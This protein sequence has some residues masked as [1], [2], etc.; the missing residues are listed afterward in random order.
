M[1]IASDII[2]MAYR[3]TNLIPLGQ[4]PTTNQT[5]EALELLN[6]I[7]MSTIGN[8][9]GDSLNDINIG[10]TYTEETF[11]NQWVPDNTRLLLNI[12][13][14][15]TYLLDPYPRDGQRFAIVDVAGNLSLNNVTVSANGRTIDGLTE[16][17]LIDDSFNG[18]WIYRADLGDWTNIASLEEV[19]TLPF[20]SDFDF[21]F[22]TMLALRLS[23]RFAQSL[24]PESLKALARARSQLHSR[25]EQ[26][27]EVLPDLDTRNFL[28]DKT[29]GGNYSNRDDFNTG[30]PY[31]YR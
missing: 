25:Y 3:E 19:D 6:S 14:P 2:R 8:E 22:T 15:A 10:G 28:S 30:R 12:T 1:T 29:Y 20:P 9:A 17:L 13:A 26:K 27:T 21:Y 16:T 31:P 4:N 7:I 24:T 23:P 5:N 18:Q 11:I